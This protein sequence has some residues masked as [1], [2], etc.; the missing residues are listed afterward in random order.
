MQAPGIKAGLTLLVV[1]LLTTL[2]IT[3]SSGQEK[4]TSNKEV[5]KEDNLKI[6]VDIS[7]QENTKDTD[8]DGLNDWEEILWG[9]D[10]NNPDSDGD[11][12]EDGAEVVLGR[13]PNKAGPDDIFIKADSF[14]EKL[15]KIESKIKPDTITAKT[16]VELAK[17]VFNSQLNKGEV[18]VEEIISNA[19]SEIKIS[20]KYSAKNL[21][22]IS[23]STQEDIR[24]YGNNFATI[25]KEEILK[26][27]NSLDKSVD[28][29]VA[30]YKNLSLR[31]STIRVPQEIANIHNDFINNIDLAA[32][33]IKVIS[34]SNEDPVKSYL[35][36][37]KYNEASDKTILQQKQI[38]LYLNNSGIIFSE[39]EPGYIL[40][41]GKSII[42]TQND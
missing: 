5:F 10:I 14:N 4:Q 25:Y 16:S 6:G 13:N 36:L 11:G 26:M 2:I 20:E 3:Y 31:M 28:M 37:P 1:V 40:F 38:E 34:E 8:G 29:F 42:E 17:Q 12:T 32:N 33:I 23:N 22:I 35:L 39:D 18:S 21:L 24:D 9:T 27:N 15:I 30:G 41:G 7:S 19:Q